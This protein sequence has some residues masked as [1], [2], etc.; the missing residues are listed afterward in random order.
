MVAL[1]CATG[2][3]CWR[4]RG[5][6]PLFTV[7]AWIA[8][9]DLIR[10]SMMHVY[11][12]VEPPFEGWVRLWLHTDQTLFL[13]TTFAFTWVCGWLFDSRATRWGAV[14]LMATSTL[15]L[16]L[17]YPWT[18]GL[19]SQIVFTGSSVAALL[20]GW[21]AVVRAV[22]RATVRPQLVHLAALILLGSDSV[23]FLHGYVNHVF[24]GIET[25]WDAVSAA[26]VLSQG[27]CTILYG[28]SMARGRL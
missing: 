13:S 6:L 5:H 1:L 21:Y 27:L 26:N 23:V 8:L 18:S 25:A 19:P 3:A 24:P 2:L 16:T 11:Q 9:V 15:A 20:L 4:G 7:L 14:L 28:V 12:G 22:Y 10:G 17:G